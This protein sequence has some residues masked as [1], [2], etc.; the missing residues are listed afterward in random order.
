MLKPM[1]HFLDNSV[2]CRLTAGHPAY[3]LLAIV[4]PCRL[5]VGRHLWCRCKPT[6]RSRAT[7]HSALRC[8]PLL[9]T[10]M[11]SA[12][13]LY[14]S[15]TT[16]CNH[17]TFIFISLSR[18]PHKKKTNNKTIITTAITK[19]DSNT[20]YTVSPRKRPPFIFPITMSKINRF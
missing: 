6:S 18:Q 1:C 16:V 17:Y 5:V 9:R 7:F 2:I 10:S 20:N 13:S 15:F 12:T 3:Q 4:V 19:K 8:P 11:I 14:T